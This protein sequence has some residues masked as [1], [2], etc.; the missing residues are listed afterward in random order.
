MIIAIQ[1]ISK[2]LDLWLGA[3]IKDKAEL[4]KRLA[5]KDE[6]MR[7]LSAFVSSVNE[8]GKDYMDAKAKLD[9]KFNEL[10]GK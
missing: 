6:N 7:S 3:K 10:K 2:I 4:A 1:L 9:A 8:Y 5:E